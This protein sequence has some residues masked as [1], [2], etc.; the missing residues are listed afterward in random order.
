MNKPAHALGVRLRRFTHRAAAA[1]CLLFMAGTA[2]AQLAPYANIADGNTV[3]IPP[4]GIYVL[5]ASR[6]VDPNT[7]PSPFTI[8]LPMDTNFRTGSDPADK[9][10]PR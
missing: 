3:N 7:P 1:L 2:F 9:C 6:S 10:K 8:D 4:G 5:D